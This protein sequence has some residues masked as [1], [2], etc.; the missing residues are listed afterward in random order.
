MLKRSMNGFIDPNSL[1]VLQ[2]KPGWRG[3]FFHSERMTFAYYD[4]DAG[5]TLPEHSHANEE[6][7][8]IIAGQIDVTLDGETRRIGAGHAVVIAGGK[9]H[10]LAVNEAC[11]AI[12]VDSPVRREVGGVKI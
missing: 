9:S 10:A 2:P 11:R 4:I 7:W 1:A 5:A 3:R 6:V 12:V 8:H